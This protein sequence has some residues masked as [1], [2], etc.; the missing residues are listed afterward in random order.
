MTMTPLLRSLR[1]D[2]ELVHTVLGLR[3]WNPV[4]TLCWKG[5]KSI[6][7]SGPIWSSVLEWVKVA[8]GRLKITKSVEYYGIKPSVNRLRKLFW[9][10]ATFPWSTVG[11]KGACSILLHPDQLKNW[12]SNRDFRVKIVENQGQRWNYDLRPI[13]CLLTSF[14]MVYLYSDRI[15]INWADRNWYGNSDGMF[16]G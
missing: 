15:R 9:C 12:S 5:W 10:S 1:P 8:E 7:G 4:M 14:V 16:C 3:H 6:L 11:A 2:S 13:E